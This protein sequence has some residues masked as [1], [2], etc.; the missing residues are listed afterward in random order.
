MTM[1]MTRRKTTRLGSVLLATFALPAPAQADAF[2]FDG[3]IDGD[4]GQGTSKT[5]TG[6]SSSSSSAEDPV[7]AYPPGGPTYPNPL[8][9]LGL[10]P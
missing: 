7:P 6:P 2:E 8:S 4:E 1:S 10:R 5:G 9:R 3:V